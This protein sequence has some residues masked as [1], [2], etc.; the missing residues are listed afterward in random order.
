M[1]EY[2][3][4]VV[5]TDGSDSSFRAVDK[6]AAIAAEADAELIGHGIPADRRAPLR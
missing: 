2:R 1:S 5:G 3:V 6:A 4:V